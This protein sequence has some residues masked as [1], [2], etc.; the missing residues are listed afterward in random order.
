MSR[1]KH[2]PESSIN[3][4]DI[5]SNEIPFYQQIRKYFIFLAIYFFASQLICGLLQGQIVRQMIERAVESVDFW[6]GI[7]CGTLRFLA[8]IPIVVVWA[9]TKKKLEGEIPQFGLWLF[10]ACGFTLI[11]CELFLSIIT[12]MSWD[13]SKLAFCLTSFSCGVIM[14]LC[15]LLPGNHPLKKAAVTYLAI[16]TGLLCVFAGLSFY[17]FHLVPDGVQL[18]LGKSIGWWSSA[19]LNVLSATAI[20]FPSIGY[21]ILAMKMKRFP[22]EE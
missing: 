17:L 10:N 21:A 19:Y 12:S 4:Q 11:F 16:L 14:F 18:I 6:S 20:I 15:G 8:L 7:S 9:R 5:L 22:E 2:S 13:F 1:E 3:P